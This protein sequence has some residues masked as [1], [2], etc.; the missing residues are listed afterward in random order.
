MSFQ[1]V[2][3]VNSWKQSGRI[4]LWRYTENECNYPGWHLNADE[5]GCRSLLELLD[6]LSFE[7]SG[8]RAIALTPPTSGQLQVPNNMRG[9]AAWV[10]PE[11]WRITLSPEPDGW[12]FPSDLHPGALTVDSTWLGPLRTG[13]TGIQAGR[14]DYSIGDRKGGLALWFWWGLRSPTSTSGR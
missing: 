10:A 12:V 3:R 11:K 13:I 6:A 4:S 5:A 1:Q 2:Q 14:G 7:G 8:T 9:L